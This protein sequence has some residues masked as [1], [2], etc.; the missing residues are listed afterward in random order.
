MK[1]KSTLKHCL[2]LTLI[3]CLGLSLIT[4]SSCNQSE[5]KG[6]EYELNADGESYTVV[7]SGEAFGYEVNNDLVIPAKHEGKPV[8]KIA[9]YAFNRK[10]LKS[11]VIPDS[12]T[13]IGEGA[14]S[15]CPADSTGG[16]ETVTIG[17]GV[18]IIGKEAF[19]GNSFLKSIHIPASVTSIGGGDW[20]TGAFSGCGLTEIT[21]DEGNTVYDS[22]NGCNAI[23]ETAT[24]TL[25]VGSSG[26]VIPNNVT[27]IGAYAFESASSELT[28]ITIPASVTEIGEGAFSGCYKL[29]TVTLNEGLL[30]IGKKAFYSIDD[31]STIVI[32]NSVT[33]IGDAAFQ[34]CDN[35]T[36]VVIGTGV[37]HIDGIAFA[38]GVNAYSVYYRGTE[39]QWSS[40][41][42]GFQYAVEIVY[43]YTGN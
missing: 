32:P 19:A 1:L 37:T 41:K 7:G 36:K 29:A 14:F 34:A 3:L 22:R 13:E 25:I 26:T 39:S 27:V 9:D 30:S 6:L 28:S 40:I 21:V 12:V 15:Y 18:K 11:I 10:S 23:I 38:N 4:L 33:T 35:L 17:N 20:I 42:S 8:T 31:L 5:T 16:L 2:S 43:D 24:N